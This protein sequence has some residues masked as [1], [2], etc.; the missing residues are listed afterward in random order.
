MYLRKKEPRW[1]KNTAGCSVIISRLWLC[2]HILWAH[3]G[4]HSLVLLQSS[5][6]WW[7]LAIESKLNHLL[8]NLR[9]QSLINYSNA[10]QAP[11]S[12][13]QLSKCISSIHRNRFQRFP[14]V[15]QLL[16]VSWR[17]TNYQCKMYY[18]KI[19]LKIRKKQ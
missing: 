3:S 11:M 6:R 2:V 17:T 16:R 5:N 18:N 4:S 15:T 14:F 7:L 19:N 10:T 9:F 13:R 12:D 8:Y 1:L